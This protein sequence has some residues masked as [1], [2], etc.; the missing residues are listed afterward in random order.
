MI[1]V[2]N[3]DGSESLLSFDAWGEPRRN[4]CLNVL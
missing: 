1:G 3:L 2:D 4:I